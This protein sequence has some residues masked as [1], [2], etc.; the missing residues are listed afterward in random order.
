M[1]VPEN[2]ELQLHIPYH[3]SLMLIKAEIKLKSRD[4][5]KQ[6]IVKCIQPLICRPRIEN[7][8]VIK[9]DSFL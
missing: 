9:Y 5:L 4:K 7:K 1:N 3:I 8:T 2:N 6:F